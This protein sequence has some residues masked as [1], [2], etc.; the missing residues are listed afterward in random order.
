MTAVYADGVFPIFFPQC[1][2]TWLVAELHRSDWLRSETAAAAAPAPPRTAP[3]TASLHKVKNLRVSNDLKQQEASVDPL[4]QS[5][6]L[7]LDYT[8]A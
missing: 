4:S 5:L 8:C 6:A 3:S 7:R 1:A 2:A